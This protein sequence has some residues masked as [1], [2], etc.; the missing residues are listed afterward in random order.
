MTEDMVERVARATAAEYYEVPAKNIGPRASN[1]DFLIWARAAIK[2][3]RDPNEQMLFKAHKA[4]QWSPDLGPNI[5]A[6]QD[7]AKWQAMID[8]ALNETEK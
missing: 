7:K 3:M 8:A 2:A 4:Q 5:G 6:S 1:S